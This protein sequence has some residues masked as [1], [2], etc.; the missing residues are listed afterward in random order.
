MSKLI[1][2][3]IHSVPLALAPDA[4]ALAGSKA[5]DVISMAHATSVAFQI[6]HGVG[7]TGTYTVTVEA[8]DDVTPSNTAAIAFRYRTLTTAGGLDTWSDWTDATASGFTI[9]AGSNQAVW[10]EVVE[11]DLTNGY[12]FVRLATTEVVDAAVDAG[13]QAFVNHAFQGQSV[14]TVLA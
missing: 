9:T 10:V 2:D 14:P 6:T 8:C 5:T 4:D 12:G 13:I 11:S 7:A 3:I 1:G